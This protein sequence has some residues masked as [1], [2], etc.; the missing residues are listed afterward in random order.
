MNFNIASNEHNCGRGENEHQRWNTLNIKLTFLTTERVIIF[1]NITHKK[2]VRQSHKEIIKSLK[3]KNAL[4][5]Y[6]EGINR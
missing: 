6:L 2:F 5:V 4:I 3:L 1:F